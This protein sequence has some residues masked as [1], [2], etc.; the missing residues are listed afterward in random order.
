MDE[1]NCVPSVENLALILL[2][3]FVGTSSKSG[4][5]A[6]KGFFSFGIALVVVTDHA[7]TSLEAGKVGSF[8]PHFKRE[9]T[10]LL[11]IGDCV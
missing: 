3:S 7:I 10:G 9:I 1:S 5:I 8:F 6:M 4:R 11:T 2:L